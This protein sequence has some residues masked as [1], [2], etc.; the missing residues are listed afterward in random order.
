MFFHSLFM[1]LYRFEKGKKINNSMPY[2][3][4]CLYMALLFILCLISVVGLILTIRNSSSVIDV[5][6]EKS[7]FV[8]YFMFS[9]FLIA[10]LLY[11]F[12]V[13]YF[14]TNIENSPKYKKDSS[15]IR[16]I[17]TFWV[18]CGFFFISLCYVSEV[19][20]SLRDVQRNRR[21]GTQEEVPFRIECE[22][23]NGDKITSGYCQSILIK[24]IEIIDGKT[25]ESRMHNTYDYVKQGQWKIKNK[26][27][28]QEK[29]SSIVYSISD[30][31]KCNCK[32]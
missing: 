26:S 21:N 9:V 28:T 29:D 6:G 18:L 10:F 23:D 3:M 30:S 25:F 32:K 8:M 19:Q 11:I 27:A 16:G 5:L 1:V 17:L 15:I 22:E 2:T 14:K 4:A 31:V 13:S 24:S 20:R 7:H 12:Y